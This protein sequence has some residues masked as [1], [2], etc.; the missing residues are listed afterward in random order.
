MSD[1]Q[2]G[3]E[4]EINTANNEETGEP[5]VVLRIGEQVNVL[6]LKTSFDVGQA[7]MRAVSVS[8]LEKLE[9]EPEKSA[10]ILPS[11]EIKTLN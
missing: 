10:L 5:L 9:D 4:I 6:D 3:L 7:L 11:H 2:Q 1:E 8:K